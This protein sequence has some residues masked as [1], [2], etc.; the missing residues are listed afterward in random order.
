MSDQLERRLAAAAEDARTAARPL[1]SD[2]VRARG[3]R[4]RLAVAAATA[5]AAG[6]L[7]AAVLL[8]TNV[9]TAHRPVTPP[10]ITPGGPHTTIPDEVRM[11]HTGDPRWSRSDDRGVRAAFT[12]CRADDPTLPGRTDARTMT[13]RGEGNHEGFSSPTPMPGAGVNQ[14]FLYE[15]EQA[16]AA[17][18]AALNKGAEQCGWRYVPDGYV[19][20]LGLWGPN[21][22][23]VDGWQSGNAVFLVFSD[24][25]PLDTLGEE[26][27]ILFLARELCAKMALCSDLLDI[28]ATGTPVPSTTPS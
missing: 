19:Y 5:A 18:I 26:V 28:Y 16:A 10:A 8:T 17:V 15:N 2:R 9:V 24:G 21:D 13:G 1:A 12:A 20:P 7:V 14:L 3:N 23:Y 27:P 11:P 22:S 6:V 4:R 25:A